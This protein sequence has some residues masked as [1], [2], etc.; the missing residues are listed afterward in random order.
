MLGLGMW[1]R[2]LKAQ[3]LFL[4]L[5]QG[6]QQVIRKGKM[7]GKRWNPATSVRFQG[8][9]HPYVYADSV[10]RLGLLFQE[11]TYNWR[12]D[13]LLRP[14]Q[15]LTE[16]EPT[17]HDSPV[18]TLR[19]AQVRYSGTW[20]SDNNYSKPILNLL[21]G[22]R[23]T[24][25]ASSELQ[26]VFPAYG[27]FT[28]QLWVR[29][30]GTG[31]LVLEKGFRAD[32]SQGGRV[33]RGAG[34]I[35]LYD[36]I[37]ETQDSAG[38]PV[39]YRP[40][41]KNPK[42]AYINSHLVF[43]RASGLSAWEVKGQAARFIGG[44]W[45]HDSVLRWQVEAPLTL[46]GQWATWSDYTNYGGIV[47]GDSGVHLRKTGSAR[48][49]LAC[50]WHVPLRSRLTVE[51]GELVLASDP[52]ATRQGPIKLGLHKQ[53]LGHGPHLI[54]SVGAQ[55]HLVWAS[56]TL[57]VASLQTQPQARLTLKQAVVL[58]CPQAQW[59]TRLYWQGT[60]TPTFLLDWYKA[61]SGEPQQAPVLVFHNKEY[62]T[63][64]ENTSSGAWRLRPVW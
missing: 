62:K 22:S 7:E 58:H 28:R 16:F 12:G 47:F 20:N 54:L 35:R 3:E 57:H 42:V 1:A 13:V 50:Q 26:L 59:P 40:E 36:C 14:Q 53:V 45:V 29:S 52:F 49:T 34:C 19:M 31:R 6:Q 55:G 61:G 37:L 63:Q 24:F 43:E 56:D 41:P 9:F 5:D 8:R 21:E 51:Q 44:L 25:T 32:R 46:T 18:V 38:L 23:F 48:L 11:G 15:H 60:D 2:P 27:H 64:W 4:N 33:G 39:Y 10:Q 30:D 17:W